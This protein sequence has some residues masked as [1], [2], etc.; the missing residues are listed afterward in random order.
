MVFDSVYDLFDEEW[1]SLDLVYAQDLLPGEVHLQIVGKHA[2]VELSHDD[3][4]ILAERP[5]GVLGK[6]IDISEM[7]EGHGVP[8]ALSSEAAVR[9]CP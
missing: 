1:L 6:G 5:Q 3:A 2:G 8:S 4:V 9:I 7:G